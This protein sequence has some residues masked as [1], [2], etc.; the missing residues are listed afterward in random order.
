MSPDQL[1]TDA[2]ETQARFGENGG[3][4]AQHHR[5]QDGRQGIGENMAHNNTPC[6]R[7]QGDRGGRIIQIAL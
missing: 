2:E 7:P 4:D 3:G 5:D 6:G 1:D